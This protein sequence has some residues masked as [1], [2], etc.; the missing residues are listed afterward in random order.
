MHTR[1][2]RRLYNVV[3][4]ET[5]NLKAFRNCEEKKKNIYI[6]KVIKKMRA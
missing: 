3:M 1:K 6:Y 5:F 2:S 4:T